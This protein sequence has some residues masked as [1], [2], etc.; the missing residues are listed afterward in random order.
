MRVL[1]FDSSKA[2]DTVSHKILRE[3]LKYT[4]LNPRTTKLF[5]VTN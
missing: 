1:S 2:F 5:S 4:E 3:N